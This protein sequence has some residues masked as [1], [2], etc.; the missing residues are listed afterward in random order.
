M[1]KILITLL[2]AVPLSG[3]LQN[4]I[5]RGLVGAGAGSALT[6]ITGGNIYAGAVMG[7]LFGTVCDDLNVC[8]R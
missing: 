4:D 6:Y 5:Q 3:C 7:G 1:R 2:L 8:G